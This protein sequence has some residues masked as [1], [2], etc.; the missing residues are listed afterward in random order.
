MWLNHHLE[1]KEVLLFCALPHGRKTSELVV[2]CLMM[3]FILDPAL[4]CQKESFTH[5]K[6]KNVSH[7]A[8]RNKDRKEV[9]IDGISWKQRKTH[10]LRYKGKHY[11]IQ[12]ANFL[13]FYFILFFLFPTCLVLERETKRLSGLLLSSCSNKNL[14][15]KTRALVSVAATWPSKVNV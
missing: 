9:V 1:E 5:C 13:L 4:C 10:N 3:A 14:E 6:G 7:N 2:I 11:V 8:K 15:L 12:E